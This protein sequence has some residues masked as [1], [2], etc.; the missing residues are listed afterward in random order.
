MKKEQIMNAYEIEQI[1]KDVRA[2]FSLPLSYGGW[3]EIERRAREER[4]RLLGEGFS[5]LYA[6]AKAKL[7]GLVRGVHG[8]AANCTDAQLRHG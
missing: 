7:M 6:G 2:N 5:R 3:A 1:E 4:A 8:T